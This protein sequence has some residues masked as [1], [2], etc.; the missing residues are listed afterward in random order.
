MCALDIHIGCFSMWHGLI[1]QVSKHL[2]WMLDGHGFKRRAPELRDQAV[3]LSETT[4]L[5]ALAAALKTTTK[6]ANPSIAS[7]ASVY[8]A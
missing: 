6:P 3:R 2:L 8:T 7:C 1:S 5:S 4:P